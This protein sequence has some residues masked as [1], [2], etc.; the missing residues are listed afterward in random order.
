[1]IERNQTHILVGN[2]GGDWEARHALEK[3]GGPEEILVGGTTVLRNGRN[4]I[5]DMGDEAA[6][7][8]RQRDFRKGGTA[9]V[10]SEGY[11]PFGAEFGFSQVCRYAANHLRVTLDLRWPRGATVKRHLGVGGLEL[12]G[13]WTRFYC[14]PPANHLA[15]GQRPGWQDI[16]EAT[17]E[18]QMI[19]HWHRPPLS[20]VFEREDGVC[21]EIGTGTDVWRWEASLGA[22]QECGSYKI[23]LTGTG[24]TLIREPLMCCEEFEAEGRDYRFLWYAAWSDKK[25]TQ[26]REIPQGMAL[27]LDNV[28]EVL[29]QAG[30]SPVLEL[31]LAKQDW[32]EAGCR[33]TSS[34]NFV[35][36][37]RAAPCLQSQLVQKRLRNVVRKLS[38]SD[39]AGTLVFRNLL[40]G[41]CWDPAHVNRKAANG[42]AHWDMS[43][44]LDFAEWTRQK[45]GSEWTVLA[46]VPAELAMLP[47]MQG[48]FQE[49]G[50]G[51]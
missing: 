29:R 41:I 23:M 12:P 3:V 7:V 51:N 22:G 6:V 36:G 50:F 11:L 40:P 28:T 13:K 39:C 18:K 49:N 47:S 25:L 21:V 4:Y 48:L 27:G 10:A 46:D 1:M 44:L 14:L 20:L 34:Q 9:V 19:G 35:R 43:D 31:D 24:L 33:C 16:P 42:L 26:A 2:P 17:E 30:D 15:E 37:E 5:D 38:G 32:V 8:R 45:L